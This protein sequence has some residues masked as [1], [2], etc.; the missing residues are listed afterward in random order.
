MKKVKYGEGYLTSKQ[1]EYLRK[2]DK[3]SKNIILLFLFLSS[4]S[5]A[6][7]EISKIGL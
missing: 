1:M 2:N 3:L 6:F 7:Y 5:F 4:I